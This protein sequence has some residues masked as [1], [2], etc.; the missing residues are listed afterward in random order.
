MRERSSGSAAQL[1]SSHASTRRSYL[2]GLFLVC[3]GGLIAAEDVRDGRKSAQ[4]LRPDAQLPLRPRARLLPPDPAPQATTADRSAISEHFNSPKS[5]EGDPFREA[6]EMVS[7]E[8]PRHYLLLQCSVKLRENGWS[9]SGWREHDTVELFSSPSPLFLSSGTTRPESS[10]GTDSSK[11]RHS[12]AVYGT[13]HTERIDPL[14]HLL[15]VQTL[16]ML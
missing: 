2:A 1:R 5:G 7:G 9:S 12:A 10:R 3:A 16:R 8:W 15:L 14:I 13:G 4:H 6:E 11:I